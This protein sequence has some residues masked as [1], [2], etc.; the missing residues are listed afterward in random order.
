MFRDCVEEVARGQRLEEKRGGGMWGWKRKTAGETEVQRKNH[1][2][3]RLPQKPSADAWV[4]PP[5]TDGQCHHPEVAAYQFHHLA[6]LQGGG[7]AADHSLTAGSQLQER[8]LQTLLQGK[9][10]GLPGD[11]EPSP[12]PGAL[13]GWRLG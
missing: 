7:S 10:Q 9:L 11:D 1:P 4:P 5:L 12:Q 8:P 2:L 13:C 6:F 3:V